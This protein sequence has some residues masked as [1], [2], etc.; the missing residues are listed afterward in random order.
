MSPTPPEPAHRLLLELARRELETR[1]CP[2]CGGSLA[3]CRLELREVERDRA[4]VEVVCRQCGRQA[5]M[6]LCPDP[7]EGRAEVR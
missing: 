3:T 4:L 5:G 1:R 7:G 6:V 2:G